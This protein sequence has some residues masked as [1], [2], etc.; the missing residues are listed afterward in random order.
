MCGITGIW[1]GRDPASVNSQTLRQMTGVIRHRGP[2]HDG[3]WF[4]QQTGLAL[5]HRRLS[6]TDLS[7]AGHQ[8]MTSHSGRY[9]IVYNG[10][11]YNHRTL[12]SELEALDPSISWR[13]HSDTEVILTAFD[14]WGVVLTLT[15]LNGMFAFG[16][17]DNERQVLT[18]G[19]DRLGE[20]PLYYGHI[21]QA[22]MFGSELKSLTVHPDFS[23]QI[24]RRALTSF[25]RYNYIPAPLSIWRG[26]LKLPAAS[27]IEVSEAG[28][29]ISDPKIYWDFSDAALRGVSDPLPEGR[30]LTDQV[31]ALLK[32]AVGL[33]MEA[34]VPLGAF[35]SGGIDSSVI[36]ALM[37]AQCSHPVKTFTIGSDNPQFNEAEHARAVA[38]HLGTEHTSLYLAGKD[39]LETIPQLPFIWDEPFADSS[40]I[41][42]LLVS[43]LARRHVTVSITGDGG[44]ELFGGYNRYIMSTKWSNAGAKLP[45]AV[46]YALS[47]GLQ[48]PAV[49]KRA[50]TM[51]RLLP[52]RHRVFDVAGR[53]GKI[54]QLLGQDNPDAVYSRLVAQC[55]DPESF[56][57]GGVD[58][59]TAYKKAP[60]FKDF[61]Q[62]MMYLDTQTYLPDDILVKLDRGAMAV[63]LEG[64][65][66]FLDHR[67]VELAWRIPMSAKIKGNTGKQILRDILYRHVPKALVDRPKRGFAVPIG[68]WLRGPLREWANN[69][70][71]QSRLQNEGFLNVTNVR[72]VWQN[73]LSGNEGN[74]SNLWALLMFQAWLE[75][76]GAA[77]AGVLNR[78][79]THKRFDDFLV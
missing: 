22:F 4:D 14:R 16:L 37:Q 51:M 50:V 56:V 7:P 43:Q 65:V 42:T 47:Q 53:L 74:V 9:V 18:L 66:P 35:L 13:G 2:D 68:E 24:D 19:R 64:R 45:S 57:L 25:F 17:W 52:P 72:S 8:P 55:D 23:A 41:P 5:G 75:H 36:V 32:D 30:E 21:G 59:P 15:R 44:D 58:T 54:G 77:K 29:K 11:I 69:L 1:N 12:R 71:D 48:S 6:I 40:Q 62:K 38:K 49:A 33:R 34:D 46:R 70:L 61:R 73:H 63:S 31:E 60:E 79:T 10:E 27:Y 28:Q 3:A 39:A 26:V 67:L 76:Q 20:K 78:L